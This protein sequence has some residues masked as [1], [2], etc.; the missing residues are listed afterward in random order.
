MNS[1]YQKGRLKRWNDD[2]GFGFIGAEHG[3]QDLFIHI[4]AFQKMGRRPVVG[5][6]I[7]Y[8]VHTGNDGKHRAV[9]AKIEGVTQIKKSPRKKYVQQSKD[10]NLASIVIIT[11]LTMVVGSVVY[12]SAITKN[13]L[14]EKQTSFMPFYPLE[15]KNTEIYSCT[16]KVY[17]SEMTSCDE[18][19]FYLRN[20]PDTKMDGDGD[21]IPCERQ[22]CGQ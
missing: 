1:N 15:E 8:Q 16:G 11:V 13:G 6:I 22:W 3:K 5:D 19:M 4:T 14:Q 21:G 2:K 9:N 20:C 7:T 12:K 17:C 10:S 18:A